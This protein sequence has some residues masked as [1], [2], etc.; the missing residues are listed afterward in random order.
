MTTTPAKYG[1]FAVITGASSGLGAEFAA[2]LADAGFNLVLVARRRDRLDAL[3]NHLGSQRQVLAIPLDLAAPGAVDELVARTRAL[4]VGL[5]VAAAGTMV[6]GRFVDNDYAAESQSVQLNVLA[7]MQLAHRYGAMMATRG[8][9]GLILV[10]STVG[11]AAVPFSANYAATKAYVSSLGRALHYELK[12]SG[13]DVLT[14][15]PGPTD[16][17]GLRETEGIDFGALPMPMMTSTAVVRTALKK[18]GRRS[19]VIP[20]AMNRMA[21]VLCHLLPRSVMTAMFGRMLFK[22]MAAGPAAA[23][24]SGIDSQRQGR[25]S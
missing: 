23:P 2:Q 7:L 18:L 12:S 13:V 24:T 9:G 14:L 15:A 20:G 19:L 1:Q 10:A 17:E 21:D 25:A 4:D 8:R 22:A 3:A 5:V 11:H 6:A 16:T